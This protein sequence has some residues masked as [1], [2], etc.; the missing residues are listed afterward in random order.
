MHNGLERM[1]C[2]GRKNTNTTQSGSS[3]EPVLFYSWF[4]FSQGSQF[5]IPINQNIESRPSWDW[6]DDLVQLNNGATRSSSVVQLNQKIG[7]VTFVINIP[8][9]SFEWS[10]SIHSPPTL[11]SQSGLSTGVPFIL[12]AEQSYHH[13]NHGVHFQ[14][15]GFG[16]AGFVDC[17]DYRMV[18]PPLC[19]CL[20]SSYLSVVVLQ[21]NI[22]KTRWRRWYS[23]HHNND[24]TT[25][26]MMTA[27]VTTM[28]TMTRRRWRQWRRRRRR[29]RQWHGDDGGNDDDLTT[30]FSNDECRERWH[31]NDGGNDDDDDDDNDTATTTT[32][33]RR[34]QWRW[35]NDKL[36]KWQMPRKVATT[37]CTT[38]PALRKIYI[39]K[40]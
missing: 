33:R 18:R 11:R 36:F 28:T 35:R 22:T 9:C 40:E 8:L 2:L 5:L 7:S 20:F 17:K 14:L 32:R 23:T 16:I 21:H 30:S 4:N 39:W 1:I 38:S 10:F 25:T 37:Y 26:A 3:R 15:D 31:G 34:R 24:K 13:T 29:W 19:C 27:T 12:M 6:T